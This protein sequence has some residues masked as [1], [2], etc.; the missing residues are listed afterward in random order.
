MILYRYF[1]KEHFVPFFL[2][3][4]VLTFILIM[5]RVFELVNNIVGKGLSVYIVLKVFFLSLP[6]IIALT[7]PMAGSTAAKT[8]VA[9]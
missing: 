7:V 3:L 5:N 2:S 9:R 4:L 8:P 1:I 6:F